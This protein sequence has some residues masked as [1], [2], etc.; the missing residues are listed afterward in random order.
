MAVYLGTAILGIG[1]RHLM[2]K[3]PKWISQLGKQGLFQKIPCNLYRLWATHFVAHEH[4][5][6]MLFK[7][8]IQEQRERFYGVQRFSNIVYGNCRK[9]RDPPAR[10]SGD[11]TIT[12][13]YTRKATD[14]RMRTSKKNESG[15]LNQNLCGSNKGYSTWK[16][17]D[18]VGG[19]YTF[20]N[21]AYPGARYNIGSVF[22]EKDLGNLIMLIFMSGDYFRYKHLEMVADSH[23]GNV[24][25]VAFLRL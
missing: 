18:P 23:F 1:P 22:R 5:S 24:V 8:S 17:G 3:E 25:P 7:K 4:R 12:R 9:A 20:A 21:F 6:T 19:G 13:C 15:I 16:P 2:R 11:E 10:F 14:I